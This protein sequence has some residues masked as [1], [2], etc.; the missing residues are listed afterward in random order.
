MVIAILAIQNDVDGYDERSDGGGCGD[1]DDD[2]AR[3]VG[4]AGKDDE[5]YSSFKWIYASEPV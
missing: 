4:S 3:G 5:D 2:E 1:D